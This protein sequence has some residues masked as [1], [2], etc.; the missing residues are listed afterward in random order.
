MRPWEIAGISMNEYSKLP[1][2]E[3]RKLII[4]SQGIKIQDSCFSCGKKESQMIHEKQQEQMA[5]ELR[6]HPYGPLIWAWRQEQA[7]T[8]KIKEG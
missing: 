8:Y 7:E 4:R 5:P 6:N 2:P 1:W 3:K